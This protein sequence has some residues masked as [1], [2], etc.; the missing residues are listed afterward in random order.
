VPELFDTHCH[1]DFSH[2]DDDRDAAIA[3]MREAGVTRAMV[4]SVEAEQTERLRAFTESHEGFWH[5]VGVHPNHPVAEEP[6]VPELLRLSA[7]RRC[8]AIGETGLDFFRHQVA[9]EVQQARFRVHIRA[10]CELGIPLIVHMREADE[11][12]LA[13]LAEEQ[14]HEC[15]GVMHCFSSDWEAASRALDL[16]FSISFSGNV[17]FP[18]NEALREVAARVPDDALLIE[19]DSPYLAPV[20]HRGKRNEPAFVRHVAECLARVRGVSLDDLAAMTTRNAL[21]RFN[22]DEDFG[23]VVA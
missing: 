23:E 6:D 14:A 21:R 22:L 12:T 8:V 15:G 20:P 19:T 7:H 18:R 4:V 5:S 3:R 9:P 17:T 16:G 2:F 1:L 10:A 13:I 11:R